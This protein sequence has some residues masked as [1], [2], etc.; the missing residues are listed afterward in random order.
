DH[1]ENLGPVA[2]CTRSGSPVYDTPSCRAYRGENKMTG[3]MT[4][5]E[6]VKYVT[7]QMRSLV[8]DEVCGE[9]GRR[10]RDAIDDPWQDIQR[11]AEEHYDRSSACRFTTFVAYEY[12]L[13][14]DL[15]KVHR[16]VIFRN[17]IVSG[18]P[19]HSLDEPEPLS[20][21]RRLRDECI[22]GQPGCDVLAI[23]HNS[24]LSDG[25]MFR[26]EYPGTT[27]PE[28]EA[29]AA[30]LRAEMEPVVEI[31]QIKGDS[32]CRNGFAGVAGG[33]DELCNFEK[34]RQM[35]PSPPPDCEGEIGS[36]SLAGRG[37]VDR[38]DFVRY[39]LIAGL[40]EEERIGANPFRFGFAASTD[41]HDGTMGDVEEWAYGDPA[42]REWDRFD[43]SG[44]GLI[45]VW[46]EEN[47]RDAIF[48][49]IRRREVY[50]TSGPRMKAR[51]FGG[52]DLDPNLCQAADLVERADESGVPMGGLLPSAPTKGAAPSF[53]VSAMRDPGLPVRPGGKLERLQ[54]VKGW[55]G[56]DGVYEQRIYDVAGVAGATSTSAEDG[57]DIASCEPDGSGHD[58]LC[59]V[60][61]D[62]DFD[63]DKR[64]VYYSRVVERPSCRW[65]TRRCNAL[66]TEERPPRCDDPLFPKSIRERAWTS[67]IWYGPE[68]A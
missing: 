45:A 28:L 24:N 13:T 15:S 49:A 34:M 66:P 23:P 61:T 19:I 26:T 52:W 4:I 57:L 46:A 20:L 44:G 36:G 2:L 41:E 48:D 40:E 56:Q 65:S 8:R 51:F 16:N 58:T 50:G 59:A 39:A 18:R 33:V 3:S 30:R 6:T 27:S 35:S 64:A 14:P 31:M 32:E 21:L 25:R 12:S 10:C 38:N 17:E 5:L 62:P 55:V 67:P 68:D 63:P 60:W 47:S 1:S 22:D 11:A 7:E 29:R 53:V 43:T 9:D 42:T 37:C 54:I